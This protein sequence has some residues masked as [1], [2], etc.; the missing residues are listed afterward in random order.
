MIGEAKYLMNQRSLKVPKTYALEDKCDGE[1]PSVFDR[2]MTS[3]IDGSINHGICMDQHQD[4][5]LIV[6]SLVPYAAA[7]FVA[8]SM[9]IFAFGRASRQF[10]IVI[11]G[12]WKMKMPFP[13]TLSRFVFIAFLTSHGCVFGH[14]EAG[15]NHPVVHG[16]IRG[17]NAA[18]VKPNGSDRD[19]SM[20]AKLVTVRKLV[21]SCIILVRFVRRPLN[22]FLSLSFLV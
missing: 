4:E 18:M 3:S 19:G 9:M 17:T 21:F 8:I 13:I 15:D 11:Q 10:T 6:Q 2:D 7:L 22:S 1:I 20:I 5:V 16:S 12:G 14:D